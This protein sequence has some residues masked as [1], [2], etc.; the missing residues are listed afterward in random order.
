MDFIP[1]KII[2]ETFPYVSE[3]F[4]FHSACFYPRKKFTYFQDIVYG[5]LIYY[6]LLLTYLCL[7]AGFHSIWKDHMNEHTRIWLVSHQAIGGVFNLEIQLLSK[8]IG[9]CLFAQPAWLT[10]KPA[11]ILLKPEFYWEIKDNHICCYRHLIL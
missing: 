6:L 10:W 1:E 4:P 3:R 5:W 8:F 7:K 11:L 2:S 9:W